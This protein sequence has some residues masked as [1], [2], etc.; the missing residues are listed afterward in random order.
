MKTRVCKARDCSTEF[1]PEV[2]RQ[3]YHTIACR[4]RDRLRR[5]EERKAERSLVVAKEERGGKKDYFPSS[6]FDGSRAVQVL[7]DIRFELDE[8]RDYRCGN[9]D[10]V[11]ARLQGIMQ[12]ERAG[13]AEAQ[14]GEIV[15][16]A[17]A[18]A[19]WACRLRAGAAFRA[20]R[21]RGRRAEA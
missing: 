3:Q 13:E 5:A 20:K 4:E 6:F 8:D 1:E 10:V 2:P 18:L 9:R 19:A 7:T 15:A 12:A 21:A 11:A 14:Y 16:C 17:A